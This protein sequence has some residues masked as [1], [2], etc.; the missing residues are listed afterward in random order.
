MTETITTVCLL[1]AEQ[2]GL[3]SKSVH[4]LNR[5]KLHRAQDMPC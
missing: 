2:A 4:P 1:Q 5:T 3:R